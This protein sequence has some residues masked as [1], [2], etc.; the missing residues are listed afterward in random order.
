MTCN[1]TGV[2]AGSHAVIYINDLGDTA[3]KFEANSKIC[4][5]VDREELYV[6]NKI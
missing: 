1:A 2:H 3:S 4:G 5:I 6:Y